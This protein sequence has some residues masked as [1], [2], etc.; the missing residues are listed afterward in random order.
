MSEISAKDYKIK[1]LFGITL[2]VAIIVHTLWFVR[3]DPSNPL[4]LDMK[5]FIPVISGLIMMIIVFKC[6]CFTK[7][8]YSTKLFVSWLAYAL[9]YCFGFL[10]LVIISL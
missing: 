10:I 4:F 8:L 9:F 7:L 3:I 5:A 2:I 1:D 6:T